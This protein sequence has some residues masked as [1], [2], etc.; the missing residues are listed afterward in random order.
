[1]DAIIGIIM[2]LLS[3]TCRRTS[4]LNINPGYYKGDYVIPYFLN[5]PDK[6]IKLDRPLMEISGLAYSSDLDILYSVND[7][8]GYIYALSPVSGEVVDKI[9][10]GKSDDYEGIAYHDTMIYVI[11]SNG[12]VKVV[13]ERSTD[14][15]TEYDD[16]LSQDNNIEGAVYNPISGRLLMAAKGD[17]KEKGNDKDVKSIFSM[18]LDNGKISPE[19]KMSINAMDALRKLKKRDISN[20]AIVDMSITKRVGDFAPSGIAIHPFS[21]DVYILSA[22]GRLL[23]V[24]DLSGEVKSIMFL[25]QSSNVQPEGI[26]FSPDGTLFISNEGRN[27]SAKISLY[28]YRPLEPVKS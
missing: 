13:D 26:C 16:I 10:F 18:N 3:S 20:N 12:N 11:E 7:E 27:Q 1:M 19:P 2:T 25:D 28:S 9:E 21:Q 23:I 14:K 15:V 17:S 8:E 4:N 6:E 24:T 22:R 5:S